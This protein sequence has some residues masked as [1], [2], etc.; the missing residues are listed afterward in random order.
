M[1]KPV[2][3]YLQTLDETIFLL[4]EY[5]DGIDKSNINLLAAAR[6][7]DGSQLECLMEHKK[8]PQ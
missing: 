4:K 1:N 8:Q 3:Q 6:D 5:A 7:V 2:K